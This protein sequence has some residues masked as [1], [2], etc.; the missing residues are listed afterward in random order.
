MYILARDVMMACTVINIA[1]YLIFKFD[2][3]QYRNRGER[4]PEWILIILAF[5]GPFG[6]FVTLLM[7]RKKPWAFNFQIYLMVLILS[8]VYFLTHHWSFIR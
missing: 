3:F 6:A 5:F 2:I 4:I 7:L 8:H 1:V